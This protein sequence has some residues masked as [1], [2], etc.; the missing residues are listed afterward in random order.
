MSGN[1][2]EN[3]N[4]ERLQEVRR[5]LDVL[6]D[7]VD[8]MLRSEDWIQAKLYDLNVSLAALVQTRSEDD[9]GA[10]VVAGAGD[11]EYSKS[12]RKIREI[13]R[14][15]L[16]RDATVVVVSKGDEGMLDLY[17]RKGWHFPQDADGGYLWY[18]PPTALR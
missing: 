15:L 4:D 7:R 17:G 6:S 12:L 13:V 1:R 11:P 14:R 16:P 9:P 5:D 3:A 10:H 2:K 8:S 18:Y